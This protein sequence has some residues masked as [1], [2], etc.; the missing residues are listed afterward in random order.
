MQL[1]RI[2]K[3]VMTFIFLTSLLIPV[4]YAEGENKQQNCFGEVA[5]ISLS[6]KELKDGTI[7]VLSGKDIQR[8]STPYQNVILGSICADPAYE[9]KPT[10]DPGTGTGDQSYKVV[11]AGYS[12][13]NVSMLNGPIKK[14]DLITTSS[15]E[16]VGMKALKSGYVLGSALEDFESGNRQ[17]EKVIKVAIGVHYYNAGNSVK[18]NISDIFKLAALSAYEQPKLALKYLASALIV[19]ATII[20]SFLSVGKVARLGIIALGRNPLA[21]GKIYKGIIVN[22]VSAIAIIISGLVAA[23]VI[24]K[25]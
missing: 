10:T 12:L 6:E 16:G 21:S 2:K 3:L 5:T 11:L 18:T 23:Y 24:I 13:V 22:T 15:K 19:L 1:S 17:D 4:T 8:S 9:T 14:G 25:F 7:L 20:F